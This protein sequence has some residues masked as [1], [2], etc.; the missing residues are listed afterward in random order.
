[1]RKLA[2]ILG[3]LFSAA[4]PVFGQAPTI[5]QTWPQSGVVGA[6]VDIDG[7][8]FGSTQGG[9]TVTFNGTSIGSPITWT[10]TLITVLVPSGATTG[11]IVVTTG[12]GSASIAF[13]VWHPSL[14]PPTCGFNNDATNHIPN[15]TDWLNFTLPAVGSTYQDTVANMGWGPGCAVIRL[16]NSIADFGAADNW[17]GAYSTQEGISEANTK[18]II[19]SDSNGGEIISTQAGSYGAVIVTRANMP[20]VCASAHSD[21]YWDRLNDMVFYEACNDNLYAFTV[22]ANA[23][24]ATVS[25]ATNHTFSEYSGYRVNIPD[26]TYQSPDGW[27]VMLGQSVQGSTYDIFLFNP[28]TGVK[29]PVLNTS[30]PQ[31]GCKADIN[32]HNNDCTH[33]LLVTPR[34]GVV[35]QPDSFGNSGPGFMTVTNATCAAG[36]ATL[37]LSSSI[38]AG[39]PDI[40]VSTVNPSGYNGSFQASA[41]T[42]NTVSYPVTC[43]GA[44]VSGGQV[45]LNN[46]DIVWESPWTAGPYLTTPN[47]HS[48]NG[49]DPSGNDFAV[50]EGGCPV[51]SQPSGNNLI[52]GAVTCIFAADAHAL[53]GWHVGWADWNTRGYAVY[54]AQGQPNNCSVFFPFLFGGASNSNYCAPASGTWQYAYQNE[55]LLVRPDAANNSSL[56]YRLTLSHSFPLSYA[57]AGSYFNGDPKAGISYD[58]NM[59][60]FGNNAAWSDGT[61]N[62]VTTASTPSS[63][64]SDVMLILLNQGGGSPAV[65]LSPTSLSFGNQN[66]STTSAQQVVT[67]TNTGTATLTISSVALT[68]GT[69]FAFA[70]PGSGSDCRTVG[71]VA[72][73]GTCNIAVTFT[74]T[75]VGAQSDTVSITDNAAGSPQTF[76]VSGTGVA[77]G[78]GS[79]MNGGVSINGGMVSN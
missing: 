16:T 24:G 54:S 15:A 59:V 40:T 9:S 51:T 19:E 63:N 57:L 6:Q 12:G 44:Y 28:W 37:T 32:N 29:S 77:V 71:T 7:T 47:G 30:T 21:F 33:K 34:D 23:P 20:S 48:D 64:C 75:S 42:S 5:S 38:M 73:S 2:L 70:T 18:M 68:T 56:I 67:L 50:T 14:A 60:W 61:H 65:S 1:M 69:Q 36:T 13:T 41:I 72:A 78:G 8:N 43:P 55:I 25:Q 31:L 4:I 27:L 62:C 52:T 17:T 46:Q 45:R 66:V 74:P 35:I 39:L 49:F 10:S 22:S 26:E 53:A 11:N 76:G 79:T 58:G 3:L